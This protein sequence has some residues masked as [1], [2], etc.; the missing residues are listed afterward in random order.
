[1]RKYTEV[2]MRG[3][4]EGRTKIK[5]GNHKAIKSKEGIMFLYH[6][7]PIMMIDFKDNEIV[8]DTCG[9]ESSTSTTQA[10]N[11]HIEGIKEI[12]WINHKAMKKVDLSYNKRFT[13]RIETMLS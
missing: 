1:M 6:G 9:Y 8:V 2:L 12:L 3:L 5:V 7:N 10:I 11:S 13:K 4:N